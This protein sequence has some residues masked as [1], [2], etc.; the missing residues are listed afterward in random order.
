MNPLT[1]I[2]DRVAH[3]LEARGMKKLAAEID[4]V[5]NTLEDPRTYSK[6]VLDQNLEVPVKSPGVQWVPTEVAKQMLAYD[7]LGKDRVHTDIEYAGL[8]KDIATNGLKHALTALVTDEGK[9]SLFSGNHRIHILENQGWDKVPVVYVGCG[10]E[11]PETPWRT[12]LQ[13]NVSI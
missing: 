9:A 11:H 3:E 7:R 6:Y 13:N 1:T 10:S 8:A 4:V 12:L 2:L 5:T